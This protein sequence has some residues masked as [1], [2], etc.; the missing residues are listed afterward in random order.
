MLGSGLAAARARAAA[1][2]F[3]RQQRLYFL[4]LPQGQGSFRPTLAISATLAG[5]TTSL[6]PSLAGRR[7]VPRAAARLRPR[8]CLEHSRGGMWALR[9]R[10]PLGPVPTE[11]A[12]RTGR[13]WCGLR[14]AIELLLCGGRLSHAG[15]AAVA[16]VSRPQGVSRRGGGAG[17]DD[18]AGADGGAGAAA[19]GTRGGEP[20]DAGALAGVVAQRLRGQPV[21]EGSLGS[22]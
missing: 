4:P 21:L 5:R 20:S 10:A 3:S 14:P 1:S 15:D 13:S 19:D 9:R 17:R 18:A 7:Q 16:A 12:R 6:V 22:V 11:A 2:S 8:S